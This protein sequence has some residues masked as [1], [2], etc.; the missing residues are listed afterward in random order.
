MLHIADSDIKAA[1]NC[2]DLIKALRE[3][4]AGSFTMPLRHHHFYSLPGGLDNTLIL[5]PSW[6]EQFMG[7][8]QV[9]VAPQ[10]ASLS[11]PSIHALYTLI[12]ARTGQPLAIMNA[13]ML[14]S[15]RTACTSAL[16]ADYLAHRDASVL[17]IVGTGKVA[18]H[19]A[20]A[21]SSVRSYKKIMLWGRSEEKARAL[22]A[23]LGEHIEV[24]TN[25]EEAVKEAD[26][27]SCSTMAETPIIKGAWLREGQH[28]DMVGSYKPNT[29]EADDEAILKTSIFVD[30]RAGALH[31]CGEL[32]IP[33]KNGI[34]EEEDV[35]ADI[36]EL[37]SGKHPGRKDAREI[38]LFKSAG[39]AIEDLAAALMVYRQVTA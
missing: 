27:I 3:T 14:T 21:H 12:D 18:R 30:S 11:L 2:P 32:A 20:A 8:K 39:L 4:F 23:E 7:I 15:V 38:T 34:I 16:A 31:E 33:I 13:A 9:I 29:R 5:M 6:T 28:L 25:L 37:C 24:V 36:V 22:Q 19:M 35:E 26:V 1:L 10:N 17:L